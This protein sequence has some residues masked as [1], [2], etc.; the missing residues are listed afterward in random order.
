MAERKPTVR[1]CAGCR[2]DFYNGKNDL[3]VARCW[4]LDSATF[5]KRIEIHVDQRPPYRQKPALAPS[6]YH[7]PRH[8]MVNPDALTT[9]GY[10]K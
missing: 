9:A 5:V 1:D 2:D 8:V 4:G 7:P 6:C 3:G 10:W